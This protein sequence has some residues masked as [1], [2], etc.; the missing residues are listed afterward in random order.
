MKKVFLY[1]MG[2]LI[3]CLFTEGSFVKNNSPP[4]VLEH[5]SYKSNLI[6]KREHIREI[7]KLHK[8][9]INPQ[10]Y[11][12]LYI[13][14]PNLAEEISY[15]I[16]ICTGY[17]SQKNHDLLGTNK[18]IRYLSEFYDAQIYSLNIALNPQL[19]YKLIDGLNAGKDMAISNTKDIEYMD[20]IC[21]P[22][23]LTLM[24]QEYKLGNTK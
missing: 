22:L 5:I 18:P 10:A 2:I 11:I 3:L 24:E 6:I 15:Q 20:N 12:T 13:S 4:S 9:V 7:D 16:S 23:Y 14:K 8:R 21:S 1:F 19:R 17:F